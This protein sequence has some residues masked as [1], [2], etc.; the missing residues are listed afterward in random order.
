MTASPPPRAHGDAVTP[1]LAHRAGGR[2]RGRP[3]D[4]DHEVQQRPTTAGPRA[5]SMLTSPDPL[6]K[7]RPSSSPCT[8]R[9]ARCAR[10][11]MTSEDP[12]SEPF[13][14]RCGARTGRPG[15]AGQFLEVAGALAPGGGGRS[16]SSSV[17]PSRRAS[18]R[19]AT[20]GRSGRPDGG[21]RPWSCLKKCCHVA[22]SRWPAAVPAGTRTA[23][24]D[25]VSVSV[26][27]RSIRRARRRRV[28]RGE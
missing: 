10:P 5:R 21:V 11:P 22:S 20:G 24:A 2:G 13:A 7:G 6:R 25:S 1:H 3:A 12:L 26:S 15:G 17:V 16:G 27:E 28:I 19:R 18:R 14:R 9:N 8:G 23:E 4:V